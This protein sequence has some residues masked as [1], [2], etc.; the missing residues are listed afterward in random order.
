MTKTGHG[1]SY[2]VSGESDR[3]TEDLNGGWWGCL[4]VVVVVAGGGVWWR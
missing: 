2:K 1:R 3:V 4:A